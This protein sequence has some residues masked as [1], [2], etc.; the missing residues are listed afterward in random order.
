MW[1][2]CPGRDGPG[3]SLI[4]PSRACQ[5]PILSS[6]IGRRWRRVAPQASARSVAP[7]GSGVDR[8]TRRGK[9]LEKMAV[10]SNARPDPPPGRP[11]TM[12]RAAPSTPQGGNA[13]II[14]AHHEA[15]TRSRSST[16]TRTRASSRAEGRGRS[17]HSATSRY[18]SIA[19]QLH[20]TRRYARV[21]T[22][23]TG[24]QGRGKGIDPNAPDTQSAPPP[25]RPATARPGGNRAPGARRTTQPNHPTLHSKAAPQPQRTRQTG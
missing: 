7:R 9:F 21:D 5:A 17:A 23:G 1:L 12:T 2:A 15:P 18:I 10:S 13:S 11:R 16:S 20:R 6:G 3:G 4:P 24:G 14:D 25:A 22:A 8:G 19:R